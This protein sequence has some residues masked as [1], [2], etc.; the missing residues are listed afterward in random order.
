MATDLE[1]LVEKR[2]NK[3]KKKDLLL[4]DLQRMVSEVLENNLKLLSEGAGSTTITWD[5]IPSI[6]VSEIGWSDTRTKDG[7]EVPG[8]QRKALLDYLQNI[9]GADLPGKLASIQKFYKGDLQIPDGASVGEKITRI[10]SYLVFFKTL[11][12]VI[13]NFN[14][15]SAGFS[16]ESFLG[17]LLGGTQIKTGEGTIADL[18]TKDGIPISLKLYGE[19]QPKA[20]GSYV[21]LVNDLARDPWMMRYV[22]VT[23]SFGDTEGLEREGKLTFY[24]FDFTIEEVVKMISKS[25]HKNLIQ[26][27]ESFF[28][29]KE[30]AISDTLPA[31]EDVSE[32]ELKEIFDKIVREGGVYNMYTRAGGDK[33]QKTKVA[34][35]PPPLKRPDGSEGPSPA[36]K[37]IEDLNYG[38]RPE[39]FGS[40]AAGPT[41]SFK[42]GPVK[43]YVIELIQAGV[44]TKRAE[45]RVVNTILGAAK[46]ASYFFANSRRRRTQAAKKLRFLS[47]EESLKKYAELNSK[48]EMAN[49]L[50]SSR[51]YLFRDHFNLG[52]GAI[53]REAGSPI[54]VIEIGD[55]AIQKVLDQVTSQLNASIFEII[56]SVDQL[57]TGVNEFFTSRLENDDAAQVAITS[58]ETIKGKTQKLRPDKSSPSQSSIPGVGE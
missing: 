30:T 23:K 21:D 47:R 27:P 42:S 53:L 56:Q 57:T 39:F 15:A 26:L 45:T 11:T 33:P 14:A 29:N 13:T 4:E 18:T 25:T 43:K 1:L 24:E 49:A 32:E 5:A 58:A 19:K 34:P 7:G 35:A 52:K 20:G 16:F 46:A 38:K 31:K 3:P 48:A 8:K 12:V 10:L 54:G 40:T 22:V 2:L 17:V 9:Q 41:K 6:A 28:E 50:K 37:I 55:T 36:E 51:G 44:I